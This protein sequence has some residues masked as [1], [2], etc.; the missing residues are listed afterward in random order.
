VF[1]FQP[2]E[3][4]LCKK[5]SATVMVDILSC[6]KYMKSGSQLERISSKNKYICMGRI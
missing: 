2:I 6:V 5:E 3:G 4:A 1:I